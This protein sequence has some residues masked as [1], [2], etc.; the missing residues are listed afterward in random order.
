MYP[1]G[2]FA[3]Q[4]FG[5]LHATSSEGGILY[6]V[7]PI[8]TMLLAFVF[9]KEVTT[10]LQKL[11]IFLSVLGVVYIFMMK[12]S[13]F[14]LSSITGI[15]LLFLSCLAFAGYSVLA[16]S[17]LKTFSPL[18]ITYMM[19]GIGCAAF[20]LVSLTSHIGS[21]TLDRFFEP[22]SSGTFIW[23]ILYLGILSSLVTSLTANYTL[24]KISA[25]KT[26]VFSNLSTVV[27]IAAGAMFLHEEIKLYHV[28]GSVLIIAGVIGANALGARSQQSPKT[29]NTP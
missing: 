7:T 1:L 25:S 26:S 13:S 2:F 5:L 17:L 8:L 18:E 20:L 12:G 23:S 16:R 6:A 19:L 9:L 24:S 4:T 3:L 28:I 27:S 11:S 15:L 22:L 10:L 29:A 14:D 21:G